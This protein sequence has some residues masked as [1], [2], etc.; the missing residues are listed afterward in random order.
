MVISIVVLARGID[1]A[2]RHAFSVS[3]I[4]CGNVARPV[5]LRASKH[6]AV[7]GIV[8]EQVRQLRAFPHTLVSTVVSILRNL[9]IALNHASPVIRIRKLIPR[10][11]LHAQ[12]R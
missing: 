9:S 2:Q 11:V 5:V 8:S 7:S 1:R 12:S 3:H 10:A 6:T 4:R